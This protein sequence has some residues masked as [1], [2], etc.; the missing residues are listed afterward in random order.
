MTAPR[1]AAGGTGA[2]SNWQNAFVRRLPL[3]L[4]VIGIALLWSLPTLGLLISSIRPPLQITQNGW[5]TVIFNPAAW[6]QF[7]LQNYEQ[8][9]NSEGFAGGFF[10]SLIV[11][12]PSTLIPIT[13]AAFAA[14]AFAWV[15]FPL[16]RTL[17]IVVVGLLVVPLQMS[18]IPVLQMYSTIGINGTFLGVWLAHSGFGL[19]LAIFLLYNFMSQLP[20]D[21]FETASID[22]ATHFQ[23]FT[24]VVLPL[25]VPAL[26]AFAIFQFLW[27]WNDLLVALVF[28]G[29]S[30]DVSVLTFRL[31][32]LVGV[33]GE[34]WHLLTAG[35]FLTMVVPVIVFLALQRYFVRGLLSGS[36]KG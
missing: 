19:P 15:R 35:A 28:L 10:N 29:A 23:M 6:S 16:R 25:S 3:R 8:I 27:V 14:Y 7:T 2:T 4:A 13:V 1:S 32:Q 5:W 17:F 21:L 34:S 9:L 20:G 11:T 22:G 33:R 12:I 26:A 24:K 31:Y 18:L 36:V 30:Q